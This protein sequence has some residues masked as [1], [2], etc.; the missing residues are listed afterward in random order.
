MIEVEVIGLPQMSLGSGEVE[1]SQGDDWSVWLLWL[2]ILQ[3]YILTSLHRLHTLQCGPMF[4]SI[5]LGQWL[6]ILLAK[7]FSLLHLSFMDA[8]QYLQ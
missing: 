3:H 7:D 8:I 6:E 4:G 2:K 1:F 5:L